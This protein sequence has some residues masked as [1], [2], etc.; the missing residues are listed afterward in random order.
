MKNI[1]IRSAC[2]LASLSLFLMTQPSWAQNNSS[3]Q[4]DDMKSERV[5]ENVGT[6]AIDWSEGTVRVTGS[7]APP[8]RGSLA[9]K[10]L[11]AERSATADAYRQL[12]EAMYGIRVNSET[13]VRDYVVESDVI[14]TYV[15]A[16][17]KGA[18]KID[19][20]YLDDGTVEVDFVVKLYTS[21]GLSGALQPQKHVAP[22]PPVSLEANPEPGNYTGIIVDC[23]GLGIK[24]AMS[25]A[26]VSK[27]GGEVYLGNLPVSPDFV[28]NH[29]I[30]GY[31]RT[32]AQA[33]QNSRVG[34]SPLV[35]KALNASGNFNTD[36]LIDEHDTQQLMG[37][38][39]KGKVLSEA[40]VI[41]VL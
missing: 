24:P 23:R 16:L 35:I 33:R 4:M 40:H 26:I 19:L 30:V 39:A 1:F 5:M 3:T 38:E 6:V 31:A 14:K 9:Q 13:L 2:V 37:L 36:A 21:A 11:M 34:G 28:I 27:D 18:Q 20:R 29:G 32:L 10:R 22:P 12:A 15:Q 8:D 25:P 7:G 17:I 41:F